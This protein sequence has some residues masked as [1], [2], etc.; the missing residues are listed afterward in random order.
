ME[1][2]CTCHG[3]PRYSSSGQPN[4][5]T[6]GSQFRMACD[7]V[8]AGS[9]RESAKAL[10]DL[11]VSTFFFLPL[12]QPKRANVD[13]P[14][15]SMQFLRA[16]TSTSCAMGETATYSYCNSGRHFKV[17]LRLEMIVGDWGWEL[18]FVKSLG[19]TRTWF[20]CFGPN[21]LSLRRE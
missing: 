7:L 19:D 8:P 9:S 10:G 4:C 18:A 6:H 20:C 1:F 12:L 21:L 17:L 2:I 15:L 3:G 11:G 14:S 16:R 13:F 5:G